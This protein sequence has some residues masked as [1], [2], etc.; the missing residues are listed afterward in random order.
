MRR[1]QISLLL[2]L[3]AILSGCGNK[4]PL[5]LP[6]QKPQTQPAQPATP[7]VPDSGKQ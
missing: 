1:L 5:V 3:C 7:P 2:A 4:G 6:D